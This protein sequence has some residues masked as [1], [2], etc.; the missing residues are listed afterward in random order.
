MTVNEN[1]T[2][3]WTDWT[4][5][6]T[7]DQAVTVLIFTLSVRLRMFFISSS[8]EDGGCRVQTG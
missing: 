1:G 8:L 7:S 5:D 4:A 3:H 6:W 2:L